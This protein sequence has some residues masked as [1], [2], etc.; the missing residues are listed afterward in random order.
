[1]MEMLPGHWECGC[2]Q[3]LHLCQ[4]VT[5]ND[6]GQ[7]AQP[8][9]GLDC[10]MLVFSVQSVRSVQDGP[11]NCPFGR[12]KYSEVHYLCQISEGYP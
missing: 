6:R 10:Y 12:Q 3:K 5:D 11:A 4:S 9:R 2:V 1:M 7:S 8:M